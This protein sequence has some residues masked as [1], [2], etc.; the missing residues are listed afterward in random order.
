[1]KKSAI[2]FGTTQYLL[3]MNAIRSIWKNSKEQLKNV[4]FHSELFNF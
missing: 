3:N 2:I 1:M 4:F